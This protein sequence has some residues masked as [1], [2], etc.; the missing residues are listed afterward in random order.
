MGVPIGVIKI[1]DNLFALLVCGLRHGDATE[2]LDPKFFCSQLD[3]GVEVITEEAFVCA[4]GDLENFAEGGAAMG[5]LTLGCNGGTKLSGVAG[6]DSTSVSRRARLLPAMAIEV[7][8]SA[9][10]LASQA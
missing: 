4:S 9:P 1:G 2:N 8:Y 5:G 3:S 10:K 6:V 7:T